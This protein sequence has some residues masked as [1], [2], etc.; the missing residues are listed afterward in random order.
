MSRIVRVTMSLSRYTSI[1]P[2]RLT[3]RFAE[4][5]PQS[6]QVGQVGLQ[7]LHVAVDGRGAD[8]EPDAPRGVQLAHDLLESLAGGF[9]R[10][11]A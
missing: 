4:H 6:D 7:F 8:D 9:V 2:G 5:L 11:L 1:G 3:T 10:D